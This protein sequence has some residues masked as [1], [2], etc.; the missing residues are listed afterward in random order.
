MNTWAQQVAAWSHP[1]IDDDGYCSSVDLAALPDDVLR[2]FIDKM[3]RARYGGWRNAGG[4]WRT[5]LGLDELTDLDVLDYGCGFGL[6]AAELS[7]ANRVTIADISPD[8]LVLA[9]RVIRLCGGD[10]VGALLISEHYPFVAAPD[11]S[12]DEIHCVGVL[13]H[14]REPI[15]VLRRFAELLRPGGQVRALLYGPGMWRQVIREDAE[16][17][18]DP[19]THPR[20]AAYVRHCDLVGD[21]AD[22]YSP[23]RLAARAAGLLDVEAARYYDGDRFLIATLRRPFASSTSIIEG[24]FAPC[25]DDEFA[26]GL[27]AQGWQPAGYVRVQDGRITEVHPD[28]TEIPRH[29][30]SD[31]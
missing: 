6:E 26:A 30:I 7:R 21:Y 28:G 19:S 10:P 8:N 27:Q 23:E 20:F 14:S 2:G 15:A 16:P 9:L 3:R 12:F 13:H 18:E 31:L 11:A 24:E 17:P 22:W 5:G 4:V 25:T 1:P 29:S